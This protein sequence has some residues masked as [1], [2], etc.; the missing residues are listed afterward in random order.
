MVVLS[1]G[2]SFF[3]AAVQNVDH[4]DQDTMYTVNYRTSLTS[5][6]AYAEFCK[7]GRGHY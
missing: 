4:Y 1:V 2:Y 6:V 7:E 5:P 3:I